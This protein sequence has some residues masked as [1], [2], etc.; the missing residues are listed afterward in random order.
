MLTYLSGEA[1]NAEQ[2]SAV[3]LLKGIKVTANTIRSWM[4]VEDENGQ[5]W[6]ARRASL[7]GK[8]LK[9][10]EEEVTLKL[11]K[12]R[13]KCSDIL[14]GIFEDLEDKSLRFKTKDAAIYSLSNMVTLLKGF[15]T[16]DKWKNPIFV[17]S[18]YTKLLKA[19]P[20]VRRVLNSNHSKIQKQVDAMI[21]QEQEIDAKVED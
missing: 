18:E 8:I 6:E 10:N 7:W 11:D 2:L 1:D 16:T 9:Q 20:A 13:D 12:I 21:T 3:L 15:Q 17:I 5:D 14:E 4:K 19:I